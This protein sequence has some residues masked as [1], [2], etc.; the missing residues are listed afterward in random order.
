[1][2]KEFTLKSELV[3]DDVDRQLVYLVSR[4]TDRG[5]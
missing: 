1:M 3:H 5:D 4:F 2:E